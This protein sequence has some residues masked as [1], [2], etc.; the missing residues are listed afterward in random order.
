LCQKMKTDRNDKVIYTC[1][2]GNYETL[3]DPTYVQ[4]DFDYICFTDNMN[5]S[6]G[7]WK[8]IPIPNELQKLSKVKQQR[9]IK[10]CPHKYLSEYDESI[11]VDGSIDILGDMNE[12]IKTYCNKPNKSVYIRRHPKRNSIYE[13]AS[14]CVS[15]KKDTPKNIYSQVERYRKNG[16]PTSY[17]LVESNII[18]RKHYK[19]YC[20][21]LMNK[22]AEEVIIGSHRD[23]LSFNYALWKKGNSEFQYLDSNL[24]NSK[25]FKWYS[26][27]DRK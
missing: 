26:R 7:V 27:H 6:S 18:Y 22:W 16:F 8:L 23:Q 1:I 12:F 3:C 5:Q 20:I 15:L 9:I 21:Q 10:I 2:T 4:D 25:Y 13:E 19:P 11:W 14:V 17:G 24:L